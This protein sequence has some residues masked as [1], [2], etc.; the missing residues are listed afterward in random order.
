MPVASLAESTSVTALCAHTSRPW[1]RRRHTAD[2]PGLGK[3]RP[4][5]CITLMH[6]SCALLAS[7]GMILR[8]MKPA[9]TEL[10]GRVYHG[11]QLYSCSPCTVV[12][13]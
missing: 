5:G 9:A 6:Y 11:K 8:L 7:V 4:K 2:I 3:R 12:L 1:P 10:D 13:Y